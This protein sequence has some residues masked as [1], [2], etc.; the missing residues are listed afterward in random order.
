MVELL[1]EAILA[2][3]IAEAVELGLLNY[4]P[5]DFAVLEY[6]CPSKLPWQELVD[7]ALQK[8]FKEGY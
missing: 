8:A 4:V 2:D 5:E 6:I 1:L 7:T 3:D